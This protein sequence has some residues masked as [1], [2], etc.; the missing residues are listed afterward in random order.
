MLF[1]TRMGEGSKVI[2]SGD[3]NQYDIN[4]DM[5]A[6]NKFGDMLKG[7]PSINIFS[8]ERSDIRRHPI[9]IEITDRYEKL[10]NKDKN[11]KNKNM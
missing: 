1:I 9:L 11:I 6:L 10:K 5:L 8:F 2:I 4:K 3:I 7:I